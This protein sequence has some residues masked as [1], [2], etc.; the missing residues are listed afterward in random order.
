MPEERKSPAGNGALSKMSG[1]DNRASL[2]HDADYF[3]H[4]RARVLQDALNEALAIQWERRARTYLAARPR[5][6]DF[7]GRK[8]REDL[9]AKWRELTEVAEACRARAAVSLGHDGIDR[10]VW[11]AVA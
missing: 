5:P 11:E 1:D 8:S 6:G 9:S 3:A 2:S 4:F 7:H 10:D